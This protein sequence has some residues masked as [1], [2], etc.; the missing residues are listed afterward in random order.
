MALFIVTAI[1]MTDVPVVSS[2]H[3]NFEKKNES[4][5]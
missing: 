2:K 4:A 5:G 3:P 1:D